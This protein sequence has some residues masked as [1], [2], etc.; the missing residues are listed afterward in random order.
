MAQNRNSKSPKTKGYNIQ[1][2]AECSKR[3]EKSTTSKPYTVGS[4]AY[5]KSQH[6]PYKYDS[7]AFI[8][9]F[10]QAP[11]HCQYFSCASPV[12]VRAQST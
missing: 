2:P 9:I 5:Q 12:D 1:K 4:I 7:S 6:I 8:F 11:Q 10:V 3:P